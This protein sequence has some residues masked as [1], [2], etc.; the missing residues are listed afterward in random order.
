MQRNFMIVSLMVGMLSGWVL[1]VTGMD[2]MPLLGEAA[3]KAASADWLVKTIHQKAGIYRIDGAD[4]I[5]MTNGLVRRI[6][7]VSPE[8]ATVSLDNLMTGE[9]MLR[10]VKPEARVTLNGKEYAVGG[11]DGQPDYAY[12]K[13]EWLKEMK[14]PPGAFHLTSVSAG[15]IEERLAWKRVRYAGVGATWPPKGVRLTMEYHAPAG[16]PAATIFVNYEMYD[17]IPLMCKWLRVKNEGSGMLRVDKFTS[18]ILAAVEQE[19]YLKQEGVSPEQQAIQVEC[20]YSF[21]NVTQRLGH[22]I[23]QWVKDPQYST[24]V[25]YEDKNPCLLECKPP[26][27]PAQDVKPGETFETFRVWELIHDSTDRERRGLAQRKMFRTIAPWVT[28]NPMMLHVVSVDRATVHAAIDQCADVGFEMVILSFWS[29][30]DMEDISP[31]NIAKFKELADYAHSKGVQLGGYSLLASR[32][33]NAESDVI[34]PAT[35]KVGGAIFGNSPCLE[36]AWGIAYFEHT[37]TFLDKT[38]FDLLEHD[39]SYPGDLCASTVHPGH[40]GVEDSQWTQWKQVVG[41]YEWCRA[42]G[43]Y[44]NV[45]DWYF[46][47]GANKTGMG[48]R[49]GNWSLPRE[50]QVIHGRQN[51]YDGTWDKTPS[52]G[53]MFVPLTEYHGGGAAATIEPLSE[54]L[55]AYEGHLAYNFGS[56]VQA[57]YRGT[58]LYDTPATCEV[59]KRW[60]DFYKLHRDILDS[61]IVHVRRADGRDID[62]M[63]HVNPALKEKGLAMVFNPTADPVKREIVLPLYYTGLTDVARVRERDREVKEYR[64]DRDY[65]VCVEVEVPAHGVTWLVIE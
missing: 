34:N 57:C 13:P 27:G 65:K 60:V 29:G 41:L 56:G 30:L 6:L 15:K 44:V 26:I 23:A 64:L 49:E 40:R 43:I 10:G 21:I 2:Q 46:L 28:E 16:A 8:G 7:K 35:G 22:P 55:D 33:I 18:E 47:S 31:G 12:L 48:Y 3:S 32:T 59:V 61:D 54:H 39:G 36:S 53:W 42:K 20:D 17:G 25:D 52:M 63:M 14:A 11:L 51:I 19:P 62:C 38:G 37:K 24:Q 50:Q 58:R 9:E 45:P 4:E 5:V 1:G